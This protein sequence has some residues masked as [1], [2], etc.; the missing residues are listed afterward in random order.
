[1]ILGWRSFMFASFITVFAG[2]AGAIFY[3]IARALM[4]RR[5][6]WFT[7]L[8]YGPYVVFGTL[9]MLMFRA[10]I[11]HWLWTNYSG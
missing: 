11:G 9:V 6:E 10:E 2:A 7:P 1:L 4:G 3:L 8:P 5:N